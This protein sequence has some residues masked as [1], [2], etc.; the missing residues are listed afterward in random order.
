LW[1]L[2][3]ERQAKVLFA[4]LQIPAAFASPKQHAGLGLRKL[5]AK[6]HWEIRVGLELCVVFRLAQNEAT[7]AMLG[8]HDDVRRFL[9]DV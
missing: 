8:N 7:L 9:R 3:A 1:N 6:G 2:P 4:C 5:D